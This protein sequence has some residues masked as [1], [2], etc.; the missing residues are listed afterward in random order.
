MAKTIETILLDC[1]SQALSLP[2]DPVQTDIRDL[3]LSVF[4]EQGRIIW[5]KWP[6]DAEKMAEQTIVPDASG[7]VTFGATIDV[8]RSVRAID[9]GETVGARIWNQ[10]ELI[11][12]A[13]GVILRR[14]ASSILLR[15][16]TA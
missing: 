2:R 10:D 1:I 16:I 9:S 12:A 11:A 7:I 5:D 15:R 6:W 14:S 3:A 13:H 8:V 4:N